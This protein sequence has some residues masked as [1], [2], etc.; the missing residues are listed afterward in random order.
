MKFSRAA[1]AL[2]LSLLLVLSLLSGC[3]DRQRNDD[4]DDSPTTTDDDT[5]APPPEEVK[6]GPYEILSKAVPATA[7]DVKARVDASPLPAI[8]GFLDQSVISADFNVGLPDENGEVSETVSG[9]LVMDTNRMSASADVTLNTTSLADMGLDSVDLPL[10][11][12]YGSDFLGI[13]SPELFA[14]E[15]FYGVIPRDI[16]GQLSGTPFAK[17]LKLEDAALSEAD[18]ALTGI[19]PPPKVTAPGLVDDCAALLLEYAKGRDAELTEDGDVTAIAVPLP[20]ADAQKLL[21][22]LASLLPE[23]ISGLT[24]DFSN[25]LQERLDALIGG[26]G[27]SD[28]T[29]TVRDGRVQTL[30]L[31]DTRPVLTLSL[32]GE[33]ETELALHV[34][35]LLDL[36]L[37]LGD[38][39]VLSSTLGSEAP[40]ITNL[41]W[42]SDGS[43]DFITYRT[44]ITDLALQ[45][46]AIA[47]AG[48]ITFDGIW[49]AGERGDRNPL[50]ITLT[51]GGTVT[52]PAE[53]KNAGELSQADIA[54]LTLKLLSALSG[55]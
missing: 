7:E 20:S 25:T 51:P 5:P 43:F 3:V 34:D 26:V 14:A 13:A 41:T 9:S 18:R 23:G 8:L 12:Y 29:F 1:L 27:D 55:R 40:A 22:E 36:T 33:T 2:S 16:A 47:E 50:T 39:V 46:T 24:V 10:R 32:Y 52:A 28:L 38:G 35:A 42:N 21:A 6:P 17:L 19:A 11:L 53:T 48:K 4:K 37:A 54:L 44:D 45:G 31:A 15:T 49:F 30:A